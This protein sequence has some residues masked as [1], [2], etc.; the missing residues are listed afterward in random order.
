MSDI[1]EVLKLA[2]DERGLRV[3]IETIRAERDVIAAEAGRLREAIEKASERMSGTYQ[4]YAG[5]PEMCSGCH[6]PQPRVIS[7][8]RHE[9]D[10]PAVILSAALT[11]PATDAWL[12]ERIAEAE[13]PLEDELRELRN[14]RDAA[15]YCIELNGHATDHSKALL[16]DRDAEIRKPLEDQ[17]AA[18]REMLGGI[19][20][21]EP[22]DADPVYKRIEYVEF[23]V[24]R[25]ELEECRQLLAQTAATASRYRARV[26]AEVLRELAKD[27]SA[28]GL[29]RTVYV[30]YD[31]WAGKTGVKKLQMR[32]PV[33]D[34]AEVLR[35]ADA[36]EREAL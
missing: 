16:E 26:R 24:D 31:D 10:C 18:L 20:S 13:G 3:G 14:E 12:A 1:G 19:I 4:E 29:C 25:T 17:V 6:Q 36:A 11:T 15:V 5:G 21:G 22:I 23:Q 28:G 8:S 32:V 7:A 35:L 34:A 27:V 9:P 30:D 2:A 33:I